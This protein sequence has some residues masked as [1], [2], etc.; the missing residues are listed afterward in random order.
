MASA[1]PRFNFKDVVNFTND[2]KASRRVVGRSVQAAMDERLRPLLQKWK[3]VTA[4]DTGALSRTLKMFHAS[5]GNLKKHGSLDFVT[6][7]FIRPKGLRG[8]RVRA[9]APDAGRL[10]IRQNV[11]QLGNAWVGRRGKY[12]KADHK[13]IWIPLPTNPNVSPTDFLA[14]PNTFVR[15]SRHGN[16]IAFKR[17]G[18]SLMPYFVLKKG[19]H[20]GRPPIP[21]R[22]NVE[23]QLPGAM[24][25]IP[26]IVGQ[27]LE[28]K[29][30]IIE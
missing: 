20:L 14:M 21:I 16:I 26:E 13:D 2:L 18:K 10:A 23:G 6:L 22:E 25:A 4:R 24:Q 19:L 17:T 9:N 15:R 7:G 29:R 3:S 30:K 11:H 28:A 1:I 8:G 27:V 12:N 5:A